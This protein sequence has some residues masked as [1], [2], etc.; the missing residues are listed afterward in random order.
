[1]ESGFSWPCFGSD[2]WPGLSRF[3]PTVARVC[4]STGAVCPDEEAGHCQGGW[5]RLLRVCQDHGVKARTS[6]TLRY[7][8]VCGVGGTLKII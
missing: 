7:M 6:E 5:E 3:V 2:H 4:S 1:M 8:C